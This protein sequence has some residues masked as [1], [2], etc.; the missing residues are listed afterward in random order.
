MP[1]RD[2]DADDASFRAWVAGMERDPDLSRDTRMMV[3]VF[4]DVG[5]QRMKV[6][7]LLGW[8][9]RPLAVRFHRPPRV[10]ETAGR[11]PAS[12]LEWLGR[13]FRRTRDDAV[14]PP[15]EF[16]SEHYSAAFP[17]T[18]EIYVDRLLDRDAFRRL[19]DRLRTR[20]AILEALTAAA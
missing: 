15:I 18:A 5:R 16:T 9:H 7:A 8:S 2:P 10:V 12:A 13:R 11:K 3:P 17:V 6:W 19:C 20:S 1:G 14:V 4:Y